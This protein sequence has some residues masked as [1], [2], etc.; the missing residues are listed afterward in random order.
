M[1][2]LVRVNE[3]GFQPGTYGRQLSGRRAESLSPGERWE[4]QLLRSINEADVFVLFWSQAAKQ[5]EQVEREWQDALP[6][7]RGMKIR[8][9]Q[10][11]LRSRPEEA[12]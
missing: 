4:P 1:P 12:L 8:A 3:P 10:T 6:L 11:M 2:S 5:S 9:R 7:R